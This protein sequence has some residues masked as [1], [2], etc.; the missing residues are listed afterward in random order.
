M[1]YEFNQVELLEAIVT[2]FNTNLSSL[3]KVRC[4]VVPAFDI[5]YYAQIKPPLLPIKPG[6]IV[7]VDGRG[8]CLRYNF[9]L[10]PIVNIPSS[11]SYDAILGRPSTSTYYGVVYLTQKILPLLETINLRDSL[12]LSKTLIEGG[13]VTSVAEPTLEFTGKKNPPWIGQTITASYS[14]KIEES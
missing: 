2:Y 14:I 13:Y 1:T 3:N 11:N 10:R 12:T 6:S 5:L 9:F 4:F 7:P 8:C